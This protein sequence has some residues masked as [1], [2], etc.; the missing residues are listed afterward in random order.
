MTSMTSPRRV[1]TVGVDTHSDVHHAAVID[2]VG[3]PLADAGFPTTPAGYRQLLAWADGHGEVAAFGV[4][5]TGAYGAGPARHL[6]ATGQTVIEVDRP[7]RKTRRQRGKSDPIDAYAAA[8]AVLSGAAAGTPKTR[9]GRAEA[10]R[11]L[12]VARSEE[13]RVGQE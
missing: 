8:A 7:D 12:R 9:A 5:G 11:T 1:V 4:E 3:R 2:E 10:I 13:R 6:R